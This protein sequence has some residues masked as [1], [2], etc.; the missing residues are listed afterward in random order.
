[1]PIRFT[2]S[3]LFVALALMLMGGCQNSPP[4]VVYIVVTPTP[5]TEPTAGAEATAEA[6]D[7][8]AV[9]SAATQ[10]ADAT[11]ASAMLAT[12]AAETL[13][14]TQTVA[15]ATIAFQQTQ[16]AGAIAATAASA[17]TVEALATA[18]ADATVQ[19]Q[20]QRT[21]EAQASQT[22]RATQT[23]SVT[24]LPSG[25]P[26]PVVA[27]IQVA[28]QLYERGRMF[29]LQPTDEIWVL[30]ITEEGRGTWSVYPDT[31]AD[32][33]VLAEIPSPGDGLIVPERGF[34][35]LW[36]ESQTVRDAL[37]YAVT[38][39][40]GYVSPYVYNAGGSMSGSRYTPGPGYHIIYSLYGEQFRFNEVDGTWQLGG[41]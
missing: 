37:G 15:Q 31:Y 38:P 16:N 40:F 21:L 34:G 24:P 7:A 14:A 26:T 23:P 17:A 30:V 13:Q 5:E 9:A 35:K 22:P 10:T 12:S 27:E 18:N 32:G 33:E 25:F 2:V 36:R 41:G 1:M 3:L 28:E 20:A 4:T 6:T 11:L 8:E 39:E 29:W 19:A